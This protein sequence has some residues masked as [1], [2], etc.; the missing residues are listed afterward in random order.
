M[1][2]APLHTT[3]LISNE[4]PQPEGDQGGTRLMC[5]VGVNRKIGIQIEL[6][7][8]LCNFC[9]KYANLSSTLSQFFHHKYTVRVLGIVSKWTS[10]LESVA[11]K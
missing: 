3:K 11:Y 6:D 2:I 9:H 4:Y 8:T 5:G 7:G 1:C 10:V